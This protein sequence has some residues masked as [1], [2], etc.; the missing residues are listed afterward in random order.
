MANRV[1]PRLQS[2]SYIS[3]DKSGLIAAITR[4]RNSATSA[5]LSQF[6]REI[7]PLIPPSRKNQEAI[8][9]FKGVCR[10]KISGLAYEGIRAAKALPGESVSRATADLAEELSLDQPGG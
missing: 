4:R 1:T 2:S 3:D 9:N 7:E 6:E 8:R 10:K 5:L